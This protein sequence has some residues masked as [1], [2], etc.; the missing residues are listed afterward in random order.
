METGNQD[1]REKS[2]LPHG[3]HVPPWRVS[4]CERIAALEEQK[5]TLR[6][7]SVR[8]DWHWPLAPTGHRVADGAGKTYRAEKGR[9][10]ANSKRRN[11]RPSVQVNA[12]CRCVGELQARC[13]TI[14]D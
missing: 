9:V 3:S 2:R 4:L 8:N 7:Q 12:I 1:H 5:A 14:A 10:P 11:S 6:Q 13:N